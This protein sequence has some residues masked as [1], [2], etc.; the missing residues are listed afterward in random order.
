MIISIYAFLKAVYQRMFT[1]F[2]PKF[3]KMTRIME[4]DLNN[5]ELDCR[6]E[7]KSIMND[8]NKVLLAKNDTACVIDSMNEKLI[9][10]VDKIDQQAY[11]NKLKFSKLE[12]RIEK[13]SL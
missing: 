6:K 2:L 7:G 12:E 10:I 9:Y 11:D 3:N 5:S 1:I 8:K 13:L 4:K